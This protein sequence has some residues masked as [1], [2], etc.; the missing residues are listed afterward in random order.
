MYL[1]AYYDDLV[2]E[3]WALVNDVTLWDVGVER[4][5]EIS[6]PD[7]FALTNLI[8]CRDLTRCAAG[9]GKY[10]PVIAPEGG[11]VNDPVLLRGIENTFCCPGRQ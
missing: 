8:T 10:A 9:Q 5:V 11:I 4:V 6:G 7:G 1:P 3:Y 2:T